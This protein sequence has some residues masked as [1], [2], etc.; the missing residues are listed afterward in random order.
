[1]YELTIEADFQSAHFL[2][3]YPGICARTHGH[4]WKAQVSF[5]GE[6]LDPQ[7]MLVDFHEVEKIFHPLIQG[8]DHN[9]LNELEYFKTL[10]PTAENIARVIYFYVKER[11]HHPL[12]KLKKVTVFETAKAWVSYQE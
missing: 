10:N 7:G 5:M 1:M 3:D 8:F 12:A 2:R 11:F 4:S 6:K 9:T